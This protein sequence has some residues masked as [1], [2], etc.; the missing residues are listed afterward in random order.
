[1][2]AL[3]FLVRANPNSGYEKIVGVVNP[4]ALLKDFLFCETWTLSARALSVHRTVKG[5]ME[6]R[7]E[8]KG[9]SN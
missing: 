1:M 4:K 6:G 7:K 2:E 8:K 9:F 3:D 5:K